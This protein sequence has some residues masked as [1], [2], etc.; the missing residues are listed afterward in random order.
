MKKNLKSP[1]N[2]SYEKQNEENCMLLLLVT[3]SSS[4]VC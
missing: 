4:S 1:K 2:D 3:M